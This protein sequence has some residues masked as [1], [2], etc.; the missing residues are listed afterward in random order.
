MMG[1]GGRKAVF[2]AGEDTLIILGHTKKCKSLA[3]DRLK[4][5]EDSVYGSCRTIG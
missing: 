2:T 5:M 1:E 4:Q 3:G